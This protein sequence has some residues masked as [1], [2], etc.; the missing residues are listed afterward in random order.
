MTYCPNCGAQNKVGSNFCVNCGSALV[1]AEQE[2]T[3]VAARDFH[4]GTRVSFMAAD[5]K[6]YTGTVKK[7][8]GD[9]CLVNYDGYNSDAWV[10]RNH[11]NTLPGPQVVAIP[12]D[13]P[14]VTYPRNYPADV[15]LRHRRQLIVFPALLGSLMIM[16]GFF[17]NW[18]NYKYGETTGWTMLT[19]ARDVLRSPDNNYFNILLFGALALIGFSAI[20][21]F[22]YLIGLPQRSR[23]FS[24]FKALPLLI[25]VSFIAYVMLK[26]TNNAGEF[27]LLVDSSML[28]LLGIGSY[29]TLTGSLILAMSGSRKLRS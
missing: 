23:I 3:S 28:K 27:D 20:I 4:R 10:N 19:S 29:L 2:P 24:F 26:A 12:A 14:G 18:L 9:R 11:L 5:G 15:T 6:N 16:G 22:L 25:I 17:T 21:C 13:D 8:N 1:H 7:V